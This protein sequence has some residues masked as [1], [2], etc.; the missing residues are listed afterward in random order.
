MASPTTSINDA[1]ILRSALQTPEAQDLGGAMSN[2]YGAI[3]EFPRAWQKADVDLKESPPQVARE[4]ERPHARTD[5]EAIREAM[6]ALARKARDSF[7]NACETSDEDSAEAS[8]MTMRSSL[9]ELWD[10]AR[11]R[12]LAF[13]DLLAILDAATKYGDINRFNNNQRDALRIAFQDLPI[14]HIGIEDVDRTIERFAEFDVDI[15]GPIRQQASK[16]YRVV[17]EEID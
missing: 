15:T 7:R 13:R 6:Q 1:T 11:Y 12:D 17:I 9:E 10:F 2:P 5:S 8:Y 16:K 3:G 4:I 14:W